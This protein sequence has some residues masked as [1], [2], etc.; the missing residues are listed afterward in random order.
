MLNNNEKAVLLLS[1]CGFIPLKKQYEIISQI[2][3]LQ[4]LILNI[5]QVKTDLINIIGNDSY[6]KLEI[7]LEGG[8]LNNFIKNLETSNISVTTIVS[9]NYPKLLSSTA[10]APTVLYYRGDANLF[11]STCVAIVGTR[12]VSRYGHDVTKKFS[13]EL[14]K[15]GLTIVSGLCDGVDTIAHSACLEVGGKTI[16]VLGSGLNEIYPATNTNLANKI[17][18]GGGLIV[19]EYKPNEKPKTY[20]FPVR[21][22][23][24]AGLSK[25]T[26]ITEAPLKSGSMHTKNYALEYG[27]EVFAVPG[28]INDIYSEGCNKII[29][30]CQSAIALSPKTILDFFGKK[31]VENKKDMVQLGLLDELILSIIDVNEV[32]YEEILAKSKVDSKTLNTCLMRLELKGII[33]KLSGNFY[34]K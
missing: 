20:Y 2:S 6:S 25:A 17:I 22:R 27:R 16:A 29:Q 7:L 19:S 33:K 26:L 3:N 32:H 8:S 4:N 31:F 23:I 28:R 13:A 30:N 21:N 18:A 9:N 14:A 10:D 12:R 11:N 15:A 24:I 34:S 5:G 1:Y